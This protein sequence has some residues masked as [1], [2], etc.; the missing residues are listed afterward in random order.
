M[1]PTYEQTNRRKLKVA[2]MAENKWHGKGVSLREESYEHLEKFYNFD[3]MDEVIDSFFK[4]AFRRDRIWK[5]SEI[6]QPRNSWTSEK[7]PFAYEHAS[8]P[9]HATVYLYADV[10][11]DVLKIKLNNNGFRYLSHSQEGESRSRHKGNLIDLTMSLAPKLQR[12]INL[13]SDQGYKNM[14]VLYAHHEERIDIYF[15]GEGKTTLLIT[16]ESGPPNYNHQL[17]QK[18]TIALEKA[19]NKEK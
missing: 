8:I 15:F 18:M 19:I 2:E 1:Y 14:Q 9:Y 5:V 16:F 6:L 12:T 11:E 3:V 7:I 4:T 13:L 17:V 10:D